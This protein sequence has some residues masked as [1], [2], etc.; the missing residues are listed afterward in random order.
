[1]RQRVINDLLS[2]NDLRHAPVVDA[3]DYHGPVLFA[4]DAAADVIN[5]LFIPNIE[6]DR[7]EMGTTARTQGAYQS[8]LHSLVLPNYISVVDDP[9]SER[10]KGSRCSAPTAL[11][12]RVQLPFR[13]RW[14]RTAS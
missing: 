1:M 11:T 4:G 14:S 8:S 12:M 13:S 5:R 2:Y 6:A 3:D 7:P 9:T 10:S